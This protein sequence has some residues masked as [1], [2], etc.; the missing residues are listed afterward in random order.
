MTSTNT[1][2]HFGDIF[3]TVL[4]LLLVLLFFVSLV[5]FIRTRSR[6]QKKQ[7]VQTELIEQKLDRIID[8]L[9]QNEKLK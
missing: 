4:I 5:L 2:V 6:N 9:E 7:I 8:L 3:F 1:V